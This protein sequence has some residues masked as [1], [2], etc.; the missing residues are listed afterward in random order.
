M[1]GNTARTGDLLTSKY[2]R[3]NWLPFNEQKSEMDL[4]RLLRVD[5]WLSHHAPGGPMV[6]LGSRYVAM[7]SCWAQSVALLV[8]CNLGIGWVNE[9]NVDR[10][11]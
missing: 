10:V 2:T 9:E 4:I 5:S 8:M 1:L 11:K 3:I 6:V 7:P